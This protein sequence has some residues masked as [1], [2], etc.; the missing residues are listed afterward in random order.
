[1]KLRFPKLHFEKE[2]FLFLLPLFFVLHGFVQNFEY[3]H[4]EDALFLFLKYIIATFVL[5]L[6]LLLFYRSWRKAAVFTFFLLC[7]YFFFGP[8][9]DQLKEWFNESVF[10]KYTFLLPFFF[11]V[12]TILL[13]SI[14][15]K[16]SRFNRFTKYANTL[17]LVLIVID[18]FLLLRHG[19]QKDEKPVIQNINPCNDCP[20]PDIYFIVADEYAGNRQLKEVLGFDNST[21]ENELRKRGFI[22]LDST[23]SNYNYT[24]FSIASTLQMNYLNGIVGRNQ[25]KQD[26]ELCKQ[27]INHS[28]VAAYLKQLGYSLKNYSVFYLDDEEPPVGSTLFTLAGTD[29]ISSQT[30]FS[31]INR[32]IR[33]NTVAT[34]KWKTEMKRFTDNERN[35]TQKIYALTKK[36]S[37]KP[38][39]VPRF[40]YTHLMMPHYPYFFNSKGEPYP[41]ENLMEGN[42]HRTDAY[43]EYLQYSNKKFLELIDHLLRT[44]KQPPVIL[45]IGDHG[46]RHSSNMDQ[47]YHFMNLNAVF[48]PDKK[49]DGFYN[50]MTNVNQFRVLL[51]TLFN[52]QLP[53]L[54]DSTSFLQE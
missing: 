53:M 12:F 32:D 6:L 3:I 15:R 16:T 23:K 8:L 11:L 47:S 30:L 39:V 36:E 7:I 26:R 28:T 14:K 41:V 10:T 52:Q 46:F 34:F 27:I 2:Y 50:G 33:F 49:Y 17:L 25:N 42:Q 40:V 22:I 29:L 31:R 13:I 20:K 38:S 51:N 18:L 54:K 19:F 24:P 4:A 43:L 21:F 44:S 48:F 35:R 9:H 45:L 37:E 5:C 1:M